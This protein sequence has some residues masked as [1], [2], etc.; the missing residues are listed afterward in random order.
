MGKKLGVGSIW[1]KEDQR[2]YERSIQEMKYKKMVISH[3]IRE[4]K[5]MSS[6]LRAYCNPSPY[7]VDVCMRAISEVAELKRKKD[8]EL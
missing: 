4:S 3:M 7:A 6:S 2:K 1:C 8:T 5:H